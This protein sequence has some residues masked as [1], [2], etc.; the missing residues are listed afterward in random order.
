MEEG[1]KIGTVEVRGGFLNDISLRL[2]PGLTCII[3]PRGSGKSTLAEALRFGMTGLENASKPRLDLYKA[4]LGRAVVTIKTAVSGD[5]NT[6]TIRREGRQPAV[7]TTQDSKALSAVELER[8][9]FLPF[10][11]YSSSEIEEIAEE[12][13]GAKRRTLLDDLRSIE[14]QEAYSRLAAALRELQANADQIKA[15]QRRIQDFHEQVQALSN[16]RAR[17]GSL[18]PVEAIDEEITKLQRAAKQDQQ[19]RTDLGTITRLRSDFIEHLNVAETFEVDT[20]ESLLVPPIMPDS[21]NAEIMQRVE[22]IT[23]STRQKMYIAIEALRKSLI[24]GEQSLTA[25]QHE[26]AHLHLQ[27]EADY[28]QLR[29]KKREA[30]AAIKERTDAEDAVRRLEE[31]EKRLNSAQREEQTLRAARKTLRGIYMQHGERISECREEIANELERKIGNDVRI[32]VRRG[33]DA[34]EYQQAIANALPGAGVRNHESIVEAVA[35]LRPDHLAQLISLREYNEF[36]AEL[37]LGTDRSRRILD[38]LRSEIDPLDLEVQ[39]LEDVVTIELNVGTADS[40][41]YKDASE[42]SRGQ[43]CTALLPLLL[44]RRSTPLLIDQPEDNLDNHF[45][46]RTVV[47]SIQRLKCQRQMIFI[48]HNAN[49]PVLAEADLVIVMGSDGKVGQVIRQGCFED[50]QQEIVDLLEGGKE[51]FD[52]RRQ[53]YEQR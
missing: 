2:P 31:F 16:T 17:L 39:R 50:C 44:A 51:A 45:I 52:R 40:P 49:I 48:T 12:R 21:L 14:I 38:A 36:E 10:E 23:S 26:I 32:R 41:L 20:Q 33:G 43:K 4:N 11:A 9:T 29:E 3:G 5:G 22:E 42:L 13:L 46:F 1:W 18:K 27:Q 8:G 15:T 37:N 35:R 47:E 30:G 24:E 34:L 53:R 28:V 19:N 6:Y 25:V 7:L